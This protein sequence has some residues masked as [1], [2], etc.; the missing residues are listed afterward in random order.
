[1]L[2]PKGTLNE[3]NGNSAEASG[4]GLIS[5]LSKWAD[6]LKNY[7]LES[8]GSK[9][10]F[11]G[12]LFE[13]DRGTNL[14]FA[15]YENIET[16]KR[17]YETLPLLDIINRSMNKLPVTD[18]REG[19]KTILLSPNDI[20]YV[21]SPEENVN[22]IDWED[23]KKVFSKLYRVIKFSKRQCYFLPHNISDMILPYDSKTKIGEFESQNMVEKSLEGV[24][25]VDKCIKVK[26]DRL[27]NLTVLG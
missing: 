2:K 17:D 24:K 14:F 7:C 9:I 16:G 19:Y 12:K 8:V 18:E 6:P 3:Y 10:N 1:M 26:I 27:G 22:L 15:I 4:E 21:P 20:V 11:N 25:I 5:F 13:S 23:K